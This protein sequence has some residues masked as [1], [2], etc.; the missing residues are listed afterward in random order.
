MILHRETISLR[1]VIRRKDKTFTIFNMI[2]VLCSQQK[3]KV[4]T[5]LQEL[6]VEDKKINH[7]SQ[8]QLFQTQHQVEWKK[9]QDRARDLLRKA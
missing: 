3:K 9:T 7:L 2:I 1:R 8:L 5:F 6:W 4:V